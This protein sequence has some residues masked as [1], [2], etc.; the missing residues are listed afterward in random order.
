[1][2]LPCTGIG[3]GQ[4]VHSLHAVLPTYLRQTAHRQP[5]ATA[6]LYKGRLVT[7]ATAAAEQKKAPIKVKPAVE[8]NGNGASAANLEK[9]D[10]LQGLEVDS[11]LAK[12]LAENG[13]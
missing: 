13:K 10:S 1:M 12:E 5:H 7:F 4:E 2:R 11:V 3:S 8:S 6:R 9:P